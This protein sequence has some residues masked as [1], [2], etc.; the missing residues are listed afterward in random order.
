M[1]T[2]NY[3]KLAVATACITIAANVIAQTTNY[4]PTWTGA[5]YNNSHTPIYE[6]PTN[7]RIGIGTITPGYKQK[8]KA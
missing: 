1:K 7:L 6:D 2:K 3:L 5:V 8:N 4:V